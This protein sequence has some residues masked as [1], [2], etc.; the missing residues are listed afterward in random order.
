MI[1]HNLICL[2]LI[3]KER[4]GVSIKTVICVYV[5]TSTDYLGLLGPSGYF[6]MTEPCCCQVSAFKLLD[7]LLHEKPQEGIPAKT[8]SNATV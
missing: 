3:Q 5:F 1:L 8:I 4:A 7:T 6:F 2:G